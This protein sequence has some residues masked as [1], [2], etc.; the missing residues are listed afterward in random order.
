MFSLVI[1]IMYSILNLPVIL[2][3][4]AVGPS[5]SSTF[6]AS[7]APASSWLLP[8]Q[9]II[10]GVIKHC[11]IFGGLKAVAVPT[12]NGIG[13]IIGSLMIPFLGF[14]ALSATTGG[15][16]IFDGIKLHGRA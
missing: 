4:G 9:Y 13:L 15:P 2:Y 7:S 10:I 6:P 11:A 12:I 16:G 8:S 3:S 5:R 1:V 14:A